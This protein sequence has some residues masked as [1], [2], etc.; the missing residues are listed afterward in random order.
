MEVR[1]AGCPLGAKCEEVRPVNGEQV[2]FRCDW[3]IHLRG[4]HPQEDR[5]IDEWGCAISWYPILQIENIQQVRQTGAAMESMRNE[6]V[7]GHNNFLD[8]IQHRKQNPQIEG[9]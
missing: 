7:K 3:Y 6:L 1:S 4:R 2:M 8:L 9:R 5:E